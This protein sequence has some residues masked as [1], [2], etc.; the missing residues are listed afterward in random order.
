[1]AAGTTIGAYLQLPASGSLNA[2][3]PSNLNITVTSSDPSKV[4]LATSATAAG[5]GSIIVTVPQSNGLNGWRFPTFYVQGVQSSGGATLTA[6]APNWVS[7]TIAVSLS[8]SGFVLASTNGIGQDFG[9]SPSSGNTLNIMPYQ[10]DPATNVP[11]HNQALAGGLTESVYVTSSNTGVGTILGSPV[12]I[13]GGSSSGNAYFH[14]VG[15]GVTT[16]TITEPGGFVT[17]SSGGSLHADVGF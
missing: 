16:L 9:T 8:S 14:P 7:G 10:L 1:M 4:L 2:N 6:S 11:L 12:S 13:S 15:G 5:Q 3:T 17:P